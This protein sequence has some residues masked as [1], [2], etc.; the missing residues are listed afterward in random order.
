MLSTACS[1]V[2]KGGLCGLA[3]RTRGPWDPWD[4]LM[5]IGFY[6]ILPLQ[7]HEDECAHGVVI[8]PYNRQIASVRFNSFLHRLHGSIPFEPRRF[9]AAGEPFDRIDEGTG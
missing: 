2:W 7:T 3:L 4:P 5:I 6:M 1:G 8:S 9:A